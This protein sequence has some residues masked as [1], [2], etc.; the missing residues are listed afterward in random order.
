MQLHRISALIISLVAQVTVTFVS[1]QSTY[2]YI[3]L[4]P[5]GVNYRYVRF[6]KDTFQRLYNCMRE[7]NTTQ[8]NVKYLLRGS[9]PVSSLPQ[10]HEG[11]DYIVQDVIFLYG[12]HNYRGY[13]TCKNNQSVSALECTRST[14]SQC[15]GD[16]CISFRR[17]GPPSTC[18]TDCVY[19]LWQYPAETLVFYEKTDTFDNCTLLCEQTTNALIPSTQPSD[20][21]TLQPEPPSDTTVKSSRPAAITETIGSGRSHDNDVALIIG[22]VCIV[23]CI[24]NLVITIGFIY[25]RKKQTKMNSG[26]NGV[27]SS[28]TG[29]NH[30]EIA[31][32]SSEINN[33]SNI[34]DLFSTSTGHATETNGESEDGYITVDN[35][36]ELHAYENAL[37]MVSSKTSTINDDIN[38]QEFHM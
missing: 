26:N 27:S 22:V 15:V 33:A 11:N 20:A 4:E 25:R 5:A 3:R 36:Y 8:C 1:A 12:S 31:A 6:Y 37:N 24:V 35:A 10:L 29:N 32:K 16:M 28:P 13:F 17:R 30:D 9:L 7:V 2:M 21:T 38:A 23:L 18:D 14:T 34:P 19:L